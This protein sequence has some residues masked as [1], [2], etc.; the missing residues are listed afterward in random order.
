MFACIWPTMPSTSTVRTLS[1]MTT[2]AANGKRV[3]VFFKYLSSWPLALFVCII[4]LMMQRLHLSSLLPV[5]PGSCPPWTSTWRPCVTTQ[6]RCGWTLRTWLLRRSSL[7]TPSSNT[8]TTPVSPTTRPAAPALRSLALMC[9]WTID[10]GPG[11]WRWGLKESGWCIDLAPV[12][13]LLS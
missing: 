10:S 7:P 8:T 1:V 12:Q 9:Y 4:H 6:R 13:C 2:L 11:C 3:F 5:V